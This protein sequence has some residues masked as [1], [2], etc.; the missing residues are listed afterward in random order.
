LIPSTSIEPKIC[1]ADRRANST[2]I[3]NGRKGLFASP[4]NGARLREFYAKGG[5]NYSLAGPTTLPCHH[6]TLH[7]KAHRTNA[8]PQLIAML[9][10]I[11]EQA[12]ICVARGC[13]FAALGIA[14]LMV[15]LSWDMVLASKIGGLLTLA[16]CM[17]LL[18]KAHRAPH[19][20]VRRTELWMT[21]EPDVRPNVAIAQR[22]V[23]AVLRECYLRFALHAA[24]LG[25]ATLTLSLGLHVTRRVPELLSAL[26]AHI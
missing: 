24:A 17:I 19:R 23:G 25:A 12:E 3:H 5:K 26:D 13:G 2:P 21:L 20:P 10:T 6:L 4:I 14:T 15:G 7:A 11:E 22:V 8:G 16:A 1:C 18:L 9:Q